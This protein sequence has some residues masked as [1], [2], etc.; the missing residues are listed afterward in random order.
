MRTGN[1]VNAVGREMSC[2]VMTNDV[3]VCIYIYL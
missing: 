1:A 3:I 2:C